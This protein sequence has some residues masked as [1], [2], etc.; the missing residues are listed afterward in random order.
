MLM[1]IMHI[2]LR[3]INPTSLPFASSTL[4]GDQTR[5]RVFRITQNDN[6]V[7]VWTALHSWSTYSFILRVV[8]GSSDLLFLP[9]GHHEQGRRALLA[10]V[11]PPRQLS[12]E[13]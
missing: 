3:R 4:V 11:F 9:F 2:D 1:N 8:T 5:F 12:L 10:R 13:N 6:L 7:A